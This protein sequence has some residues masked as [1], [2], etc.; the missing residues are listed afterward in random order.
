MPHL[1]LEISNDIAVDNGMKLLETINHALIKTE[2]FKAVDIKSRIYHPSANLVGLPSD[3]QG[4]VYA[5]LSM[6]AGR[7]DAIKQHLATLILTILK[8]QFGDKVQY[9]VA[10]DDLPNHYIKG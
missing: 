7:D 1:T 4:F 5:R 3:V 8:E 10:I 2:V 6:L 9:G